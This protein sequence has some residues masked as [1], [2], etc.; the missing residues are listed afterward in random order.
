MRSLLTSNP[1]FGLA[2]GL[3]PW[4]DPL[5][6]G[7]VPTYGFKLIRSFPHDKSAFTQGLYYESRRGTLLEST[8]MYGQSSARRVEITSGRVIDKQSLREDWFGEG[9][10]VHDRRVIQLLWREGLGLLRNRRTLELEGNFKLPRSMEE[11]WGLTRD[12]S[13][14]LYATD[15]TATLHVLDGSSLKVARSMEVRA[16]GRPLRDLNEL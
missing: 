12:D 14:T 15:G 3:M 1:L 13:G 8:G 6:A 4:L 5:S 11:G 16:A 2:A 9:I 10:V 7:E